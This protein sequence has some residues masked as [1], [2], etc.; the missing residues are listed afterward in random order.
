VAWCLPQVSELVGVG[1]LKSRWHTKRVAGKAVLERVVDRACSGKARRGRRPADGPLRACVLDDT[2][3]AL[4]AAPRR[5]LG[6][7]PSSRFHTPWTHMS[8]V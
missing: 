5:R 7:M 8:R 1:C 4:S 3:A 6:G 2:T